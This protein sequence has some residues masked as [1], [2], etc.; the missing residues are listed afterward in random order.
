MC[1][2]PPVLGAREGSQPALQR[3]STSDGMSTRPNVGVMVGPEFVETIDVRPFIDAFVFLIVNPL[4]AAVPTQLLASTLPGKA[5]SR[6]AAAAMVPLMMVTFAVVVASQIFHVSEQM[7]LLL[8]VIPVAVLFAAVMFPS[9]R[10]PATSRDWT[11]PVD[12]LSSS[13]APPATRWSSSCWSS[14]YRPGSRSRHSWLSAGGRG[15][16]VSRKR[17]RVPSIHASRGP[18]RCAA[19]PDHVR[20]N[21]TRS[22]NGR[23]EPP[24]C[25][26]VLSRPDPCGNT[27][28]TT[29]RNWT[30]L[31]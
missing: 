18:R 27:V 2:D 7:S 26:P 15:G 13:A 12:E 21:R 14:P 31:S 24:Q 16:L 22:P 30:G 3:V 4:A 25:C 5:V 28:A 23:R 20:E 8:P 11:Y 19:A 17:H 6:I 9:A 29:E 10:S 1:R